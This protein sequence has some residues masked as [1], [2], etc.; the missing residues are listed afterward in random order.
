MMFKSPEWSRIT[1]YAAE[2]RI[3]MAIEAIEKAQDN[4]RNAR[5]LRL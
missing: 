2:N 1:A 5:I 4:G 3:K